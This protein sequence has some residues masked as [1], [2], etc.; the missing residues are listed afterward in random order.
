MLESFWAVR[1]INKPNH[2]A[3][4]IEDKKIRKASSRTFSISKERLF[5][6]WMV[7]GLRRSRMSSSLE[8]HLIIQ[9]SCLS[10]KFQKWPPMLRLHRRLSL[11]LHPTIAA[12]QARRC[13]CDAPAPA[14]A[15]GWPAQCGPYMCCVTSSVSRSR[16]RAPHALRLPHS[17]WRARVG[18]IATRMRRPILEPAG[19]G[20]PSAGEGTVCCAARAA[21]GRAWLAAIATCRWRHTLEPPAACHGRLRQWLCTHGTGTVLG[22]L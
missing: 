20:P 12:S 21:R 14:T 19:A 3:V 13:S 7:K 4:L 18:A 15:S 11:L 9:L 22:S 10:F 5:H 16:L 8:C 2:H 17:T 1:L 6:L